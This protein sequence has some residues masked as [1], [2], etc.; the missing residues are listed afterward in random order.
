MGDCSETLRELEAF[1]DQELTDGGQAVIHAHLEHCPDC[2]EAN[3]FHAE[4]KAVIAQKCRGDQLPP[5]LAERIRSCFG[6]DVAPPG[7]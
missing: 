4:L 7:I 2:L 5:G 1:L 3:E 6:D